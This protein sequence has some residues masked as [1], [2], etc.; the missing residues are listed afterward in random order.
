[1]SSYLS[2]CARREMQRQGVLKWV[3]INGSW[4]GLVLN[5]PLRPGTAK[6]R[7]KMNRRNYRWEIYLRFF[8]LPAP[9]I[10]SMIFTDMKVM[11][12]LHRIGHCKGLSFSG[13]WW[14]LEPHKII[15]VLLPCSVY[16]FSCKLFPSLLFCAEIVLWSLV[17]GLEFCGGRERGEGQERKMSAR[18]SIIQRTL[19]RR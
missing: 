18:W 3:V 9:P 13:C 8:S 17:F 11:L 6:E 10:L 4:M 16:P 12:A 19:E 2:P 5:S 14:C 1:M 7:K 15:V